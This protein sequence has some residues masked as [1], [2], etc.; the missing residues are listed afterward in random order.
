MVSSFP[1][2]RGLGCVDFSERRRPG[3]ADGVIG[4][5]SPIALQ[6]NDPRR[7]VLLAPA[8]RPCCI[9]SRSPEFAASMKPK[10]KL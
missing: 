10:L 6:I 8:H 5:F 3:D 9:S 7:E 1:Y 4:G 2:Y